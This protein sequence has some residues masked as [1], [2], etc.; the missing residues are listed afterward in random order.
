MEPILSSRFGL[1]GPGE[2]DTYQSIRD[3]EGGMQRHD[4]LRSGLPAMCS[5]ANKQC[6]FLPLD[7]ID[8]RCRNARMKRMKKNRGYCEES[9]PYPPSAFEHAA[10]FA[11]WVR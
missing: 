6:C 7:K 10:S 4:A 11:G 9:R 1:H 3:P 5:A 2:N 8:A